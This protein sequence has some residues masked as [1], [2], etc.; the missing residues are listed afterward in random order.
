MGRFHFLGTQHESMDWI[1]A[2]AVR[3]LENR[4]RAKTH[5]KT[6]A[7]KKQMAPEALDFAKEAL[8]AGGQAT[9]VRKILQ[10]KFGTHLISKDLINI[11]Q[12]LAGKSC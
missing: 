12:G 1:L 6:Y 2:E 5:L 8:S 7:S 3:L 11:K 10:D 9:K 4:V